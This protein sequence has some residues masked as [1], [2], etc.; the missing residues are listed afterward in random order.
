MSPAD[1]RD[2]RN[3]EPDLELGIIMKVFN[4]KLFLALLG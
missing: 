4:T 1:I 2:P 3:E